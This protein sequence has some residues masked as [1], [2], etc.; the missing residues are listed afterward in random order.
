MSRPRS[1]VVENDDVN[2]HVAEIKFVLAALVPW[3]R[4]KLR[5]GM[6]PSSTYMY[7]YMYTVDLSCG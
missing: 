5:Q 3:E 6:T 4:A 2:M 7:M 1:L